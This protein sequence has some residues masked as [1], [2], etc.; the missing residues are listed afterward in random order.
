[1]LFPVTAAVPGQGANVTAIL[2]GIKKVEKI[3][4]AAKKVKGKILENSPS[5]GAD[6]GQAL[7]RSLNESYT[8]LMKGGGVRIWVKVEYDVVI[9]CKGDPYWSHDD[10]D[11]GW[12]KSDLGTGNAPRN[13]GDPAGYDASETAAILR[14]IPQ[15]VNDAIKQVIDNCTNTNYDPTMD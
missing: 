9:L 14:D 1:M 10:M 2:E 8:D 13:L 7:A 4:D 3:N 5:G 11:Y 12:H 6:S 15:A